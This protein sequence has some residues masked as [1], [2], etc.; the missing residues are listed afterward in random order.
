[1]GEPMEATAA[2]VGTSMGSAGSTMTGD[3]LMDKGVRSLYAFYCNS[4]AEMPLPL[5]RS[6]HKVIF[7]SFST[8]PTACA[9]ASYVMPCLVCRRQDGA[10]AQQGERS[11]QQPRPEASRNGN[12][13]QARNPNDVSSRPEPKA[14]A[15]EQAPA[16]DA[17]LK[18]QLQPTPEASPA[19]AEP[20]IVFNEQQLSEPE[21]AAAESTPQPEQSRAADAAETR[22]EPQDTS[23]AAAAQARPQPKPES[24]GRPTAPTP[25]AEVAPRPQVRNREQP[26]GS[27]GMDMRPPPSFESRIQLRTSGYADRRERPQS[28]PTARAPMSEAPRRAE[29]ARQQQRPSEIPQLVQDE[30]E[31]STSDSSN[32]ESATPAPPTQAPATTF[33]GVYLKKE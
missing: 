10:D 9:A 18:P 20:E 14:E 16:A 30:P 17:A 7:I 28:A 19:K 1:M 26:R 3:Q 2:G 5:L 32:A 13:E 31:P 4:Q 11:M 15:S 12:R 21:P 22:P 6:L 29:P 27:S 33:T 23:A 24:I 8:C 25:A